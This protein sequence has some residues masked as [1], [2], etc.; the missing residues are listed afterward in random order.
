MN[1]EVA[2]HARLLG[3]V[4]DRIS[5][6]SFR[7][8][9]S[10]TV[11]NGRLT[12]R[13]PSSRLSTR[14]RRGPPG[15]RPLRPAPGSGALMVERLRQDPGPGRGVGEPAEGVP[16]D[17]GV[18]A[19]VGQ[20]VDLFDAGRRLDRRWLFG[21]E[22]HVGER[23]R[24]QNSESRI[25]NSEFR[26]QK[27]KREAGIFSIPDSISSRFSLSQIIV[28]GPLGRWHGC[29]FLNAFRYPFDLSLR[30]IRE[31]GEADDFLADSFP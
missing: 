18:P 30:Q 5:S 29:E 21:S 14:N 8:S 25:Q 9:G 12:S 11:V 4:A 1:F 16:F 28:L 17:E 22:G 15:C 10:Q 23:I 20:R 26:I 2:C 27:M 3:R 13:L 31:H 7:T 19:G 24:I 6:L